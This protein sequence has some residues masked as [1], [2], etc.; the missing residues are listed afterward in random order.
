MNKW[1]TV[2]TEVLGALVANSQNDLV[3]KWINSTLGIDT[4]CKC[5]AAV[6]RKI[7]EAA[8]REMKYSHLEEAA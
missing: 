8:M 4:E 1:D 7:T 5:I 2:Y 3:D 6:A